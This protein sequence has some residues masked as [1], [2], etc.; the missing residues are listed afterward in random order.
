MRSIKFKLNLLFLVLVLFVMISSAIFIRISIQNNESMRIYTELTDIVTLINSQIIQTYIYPS[1]IANE[2]LGQSFLATRQGFRA[3]LL[4][5]NGNSFTGGVYSSSVIIAAMAGNIGY[6]A[7]ERTDSIQEGSVSIWMSY[8]TPITI[9][10]TGEVVILYLRQDATVMWE[11]LDATTITLILAIALSMVLAAILGTIFAS[12]LTAPI[13]ALT[14]KTKEMSKGNFLAIPVYSNDEIGQLTQSFNQMGKSLQT[15]LQN[16]NSEKTRNE[17]I[18]HSMTDGII[19]FDKSGQLIHANNAAIEMIG[20]QNIFYAD[21]ISLLEINSEA[22]QDKILELGD[23][24]IQRSF[25][26]YENAN[27]D[28]DGTVIV[29]Q[30]ATKRTLLDNMRKEFV[31][32]VSHEIRTPLTVIKTYAETLLDQEEDELRKSFLNTINLE[33]DRM[34]LLAAD[35]L[36]LSHFDNKQL[37]I[38]NSNNDLL[39]ILK[40]SIAQTQIIAEKKGQVIQ[41]IQNGDSMPF[42]C[43]ASRINQVFVNIISNSIKYSPEK[44]VISIV[45]DKVEDGYNIYI[46]DNG[47]GIPKEDYDRIFERFYRVDKARS[48]AMGG[49]GLGLS[50]V[51]EIL[52]L[53]NGEISIK[54]EKGKGTT[55]LIT[56]KPRLKACVVN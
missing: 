49:I 46:K 36:E 38:N 32:N 5:S 47:I 50:I 53:Q 11:S 13:S 39:Q 41:Y 22:L 34:T 48:R 19:A 12:T 15:T 52:N 40:N 44:S 43:D 18:I 3:V 7:W 54:S 23:K 1:I 2:L 30:D 28:I 29:L 37:K 6:N 10:A 51:K 16:M 25:T 17:I 21:T 33:V 45:C 26:T 27:G 14:K 56:F 20:S 9:V 4:D 42:F 35:L 24:Y 8:A 31:A 55:V